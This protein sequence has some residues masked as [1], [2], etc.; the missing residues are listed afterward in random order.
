[1]TNSYIE[2]F[3]SKTKLDGATG[4]IIWNGAR[5][6]CGYGIFRHKHTNRVAWEIANGE[7]PLGKDVLHKCDNPPCV[8]P[9][10][11]CV[12]SHSDNMADMVLKGRGKGPSRPGE[13][14]PSAKFTKKDVIEIRRLFATG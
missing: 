4:C 7:I 13:D 9:E 14:N 1:M 12:G 2:S 10:H 8:N 3:F 5:D 6:Y 11:L